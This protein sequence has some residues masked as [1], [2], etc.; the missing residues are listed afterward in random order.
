MSHIIP[1]SFLGFDSLIYLI[2]AIIGFVVAYYAY[3][4]HQLTSN[5]SHAY[6][7]YGFAILSIGFLILSLT[8]FYSF[9]NYKVLCTSPENCYS[10]IFDTTWDM[11]DFGYWIYYITSLV[12]YSLFALM[13]LPELRKK[14][15]PV[16]GIFAWW[17]VF[18]YFHLL[19]FLIIC[20]VIFKSLINYLDSRNSN[21]F[22]VFLA[23]LLMGLF[24]VMLFLTTYGKVIY[25]AAHVL[26]FIGFIS[27]LSVLVRISRKK[28]LLGG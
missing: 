10:A 27:L 3:K 25:V 17:V 19:S 18:P 21:T 5:R 7:Y 11:R 14:A 12:G 13:Y 26:L 20:Y 2:A 22:L 15:A 6:L 9:V 28:H 8:S 24:H 4:T 23:F 16:F 1:Y